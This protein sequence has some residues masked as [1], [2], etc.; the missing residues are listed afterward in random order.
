MA[1][2]YVRTGLQ[3][4]NT[5][6][7][8]VIISKYDP[9]AGPIPSQITLNQLQKKAL[10]AFGNTGPIIIEQRELLSGFDG[11]MGRIQ[12]W[13]IVKD[14]ALGKFDDVGEKFLR[15]VQAWLVLGNEEFNLIF[16]VVQL[17]KTALNRGFEKLG[18]L[19]NELR[20]IFPR[21]SRRKKR[22]EAEIQA[23]MEATSLPVATF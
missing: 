19:M 6:L 20:R 22:F 18:D 8:M 4:T 17:V 14:Y 13:N 16:K 10:N 9:S 23:V 21:F 11:T 7:D 1:Y 2:T 5:Q 15:L 3:K 12:A